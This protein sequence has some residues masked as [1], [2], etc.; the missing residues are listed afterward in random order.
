MHVMDGYE[1]TKQIRGLD[2]EDA[3]TIPI[4]ALSANALADDVENALDA[5]MNEHIAKP[6]DMEIVWK[7][8]KRYLTSSN[9]PPDSIL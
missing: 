9:K 6:I 4:I 8:L 3:K 2:K 1:A 5:G 7:I